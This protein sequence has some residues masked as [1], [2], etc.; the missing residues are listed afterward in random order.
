MAG[1]FPSSKESVWQLAEKEPEL[2]P[3]GHT[4]RPMTSCQGIMKGAEGPSMKLQQGKSGWILGK[5]SS[6]WGCSE[7]SPHYLNFGWSDA[8]SEVKLADLCESLPNR[9]IVWFYDYQASLR[10]R[11]NFIWRV[12]S[13][14]TFCAG[15]IKKLCLHFYDFL[16]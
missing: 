4:W 13:S 3:G 12:Q 9:D 10:K 1:N 15:K 11:R 2:C 8:E 6:L 14:T 5:G 7:Q 16:Y